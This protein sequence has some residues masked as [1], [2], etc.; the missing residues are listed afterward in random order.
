MANIIRFGGG[1][2]TGSGSYGTL[3]A[4]VINFYASGGNAQ[5][6][7]MWTNPTDDNFAGVAIIRKTGGYP[8]SPTDGTKIYTGTAQTYTDTGLTNDV[9]YYYRAFAY[10]SKT[11]YQT[12][13][14]VATAI[15]KAG[16]LASTLTVGAKIKLGI[17]YGQPIIWNIIDKNHTGYPANSVTLMSDKVL[18]LK[19]FDAK[20]P[21]NPNS[22][23][24]SS[25][26]NRYSVANI[27][28]WINSNAGTG[29][30][31]SAQH[32]YDAPPSNDN[33]DSGYNDY[34]TQPGFMNGFSATAKSA[35][36]DTT[37]ITV[38]NKDTDGGGSETTVSKMFLPS[39]TEMGLGDENIISE[40]TPFSIFNSDASRQSYPTSECVANSEYTN[41]SLNVSL[42]WDYWLRTPN[43]TFSYVERTIT[44]SGTLSG[45]NSDFGFRGV[46]PC[47]NISGDTLVSAQV[48]ADDCY[49]LE[50]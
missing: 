11:E 7:L 4:Q 23:R 6:T 16:I 45:Q 50:G 19:C 14:I 3:P 46:R 5:V 9:Q 15:P 30:W 49:T 25:G 12:I 34:D 1:T 35:L 10:N 47:C 26:N 33:V 29:A 48:D 28:Q 36:L 17:Y 40:G 18:T 31:Y 2:S 39:E 22:A 42:A 41:S 43:T 44:S 8:T 13:Y 27:R 20:E 24:T 21:T 38:L 37:L 32:Q